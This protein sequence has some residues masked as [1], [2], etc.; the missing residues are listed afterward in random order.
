MGIFSKGGKLLADGAR[1]RGC[2]CEGWRLTAISYSTDRAHYC[3]HPIVTV[4][5][6]DEETCIYGNLSNAVFDITRRTKI[7]FSPAYCSEGKLC[8]PPAESSF[9]EEWQEAGNT[10]TAWSSAFVYDYDANGLS[11]IVNYRFDMSFVR[12][13]A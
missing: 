10:A 6:P 8:G 2:C 1:L 13:N 4:P 7:D 5:D 9:P 12:C 3:C 11:F